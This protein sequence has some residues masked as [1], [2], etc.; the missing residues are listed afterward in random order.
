MVIL[1]SIRY[2][3]SGCSLL[4]TSSMTLEVYPFHVPTPI[5]VEC[6]LPPELAKDPVED[7]QDGHPAKHLDI[8]MVGAASFLRLVRRLKCT[9]FH[10]SIHAIDQTIALS[11]SAASAVDFEKSLATKPDIDP[12]TKT[13]TEYHDHTTTRPTISYNESNS[14]SAFVDLGR[15]PSIALS[16]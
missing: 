15:D 12:A 13:P 3:D 1:R 14:D 5:H 10:I 9:P 7:D 2:C 4:P 16:K 6:V 11:L 8:A